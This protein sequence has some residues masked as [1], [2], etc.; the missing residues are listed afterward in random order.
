MRHGHNSFG[1]RSLVHTAYVSGQGTRGRYEPADMVAALPE[2]LKALG[3]VLFIF[4]SISKR[5]GKKRV[6]AI[7]TTRGRR[8]VGG[9]VQV[10]L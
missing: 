7:R 8:G 5:T 3:D 10:I 6:N 9:G 1:P 2:I 4:V